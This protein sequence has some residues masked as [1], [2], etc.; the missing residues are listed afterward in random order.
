MFTSKICTQK[1]ATTIPIISFHH[2]F[3]IIFNIM[4]NIWINDFCVAQISQEITRS[5]TKSD[6]QKSEAHQIELNICFFRLLI[7]NTQ[8]LASAS[9]YSRQIYFLF[10]F[11]ILI[12]RLERNICNQRLCFL[13]CVP[14]KPV[15]INVGI[16]SIKIILLCSVFVPVDD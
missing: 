12:N 5:E 7:I 14:F 2:L 15:W 6:F 3:R 9:N 1:R 10:Q 13:F 16:L 11:R 8:N 4:R